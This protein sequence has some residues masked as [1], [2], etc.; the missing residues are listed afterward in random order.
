M[1][2]ITN[3]DTDDKD[4]DGCKTGELMEGPTRGNT[5][6]ETE[7]TLQNANLFDIAFNNRKKIMYNKNSM[8][9]QLLHGDDDTTI[10]SVVSLLESSSSM[11]TTTEIPATTTTRQQS[12][13]H[14]LNRRIERSVQFLRH[15]SIVQL[16]SIEKDAYLSS[17]GLSKDEIKIS[18]ETLTRT[19]P[20]TNTTTVIDGNTTADF[21]SDCDGNSDS[22]SINSD[23]YIELSRRNVSYRRT[24]RGGDED[25]TKSGGVHIPVVSVIDR[26]IVQEQQPQ[27]MDSFLT[28]VIAQVFGKFFIIVAVLLGLVVATVLLPCWLSSGED[29]FM[30]LPSTSTSAPTTANT[31]ITQTF[32]ARLQTRAKEKDNEILLDVV[33]DQSKEVEEIDTYGDVIAST[34]TVLIASSIP[35]DSSPR[36]IDNRLHSGIKEKNDIHEKKNLPICEAGGSRLNVPL[37]T[38]EKNKA[39]T[40]T[41]DHSIYEVEEIEEKGKEYDVYPSDQA[42]TDVNIGQ[43]RHDMDGIG[44]I[45]QNAKTCALQPNLQNVKLPLQPHRLMNKSITHFSSLHKRLSMLPLTD[46]VKTRVGSMADSQNQD[47]TYLV[48][49]EL[50]GRRAVHD[51][52]ETTAR[53]ENRHEILSDFTIL[54]QLAE[55]KSMLSSIN[56]EIINQRYSSD[57]YHKQNIDDSHKE[58]IC[59]KNVSRPCSDTNNIFIK[60]EEISAT[61]SRIESKLK[62]ERIIV[63]ERDTSKF[64]RKAIKKKNKSDTISNIHEETSCGQHGESFKH[65]SEK[66]EYSTRIRQDFRYVNSNKTE[67]AIFKRALQILGGIISKIKAGFK[68]ILRIP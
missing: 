1:M 26:P 7:T 6:V 2:E 46:K 58:G 30:C 49:D 37:F 17:K 61:V 33:I 50:L 27:S 18:K 55:L 41:K 20:G 66:S 24:R 28:P 13:Q 43:Y 57:L 29:Y 36:H 3:I 12:Q 44:D 64:E 23:D 15:P 11:A 63:Q 16:S 67:L 31:A 4:D 35:T 47:T 22:D 5:N 53:N 25:S 65:I 42:S 34:P 8:R 59:N 48:V 56:N 32:D 19:I 14:K 39:C 38:W 51:Y 52:I 9:H 40:Y 21:D 60:F 45:M 54:A 62:C 68:I 10:T